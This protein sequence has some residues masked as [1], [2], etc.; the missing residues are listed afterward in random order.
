MSLDIMARA[1]TIYVILIRGGGGSFIGLCVV[2]R[3]VRRDRRDIS[4][5]YNRLLAGGINKLP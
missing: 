2:C 3:A 5:A 1:L 4:V